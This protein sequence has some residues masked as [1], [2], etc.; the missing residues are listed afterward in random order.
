VTLRLEGLP[1]VQP[2]VTLPVTATGIRGKPLLPEPLGRFYDERCY[3]PQSV[4]GRLLELYQASDARKSDSPLTEFVKDLLGLDQ[5]DALIDGLRDAGDIRRLRI[6]LP[7]YAE[8]R[9]E[10]QDQE[11]AIRAHNAQLKELSSQIAFAEDTL[12]QT[13]SA[14]LLNLNHDSSNIDLL[15]QQLNRSAEERR[16]SELARIQRRLEAARDEWQSIAISTAAEQ[17]QRLEIQ[18]AATREHA[19]RW[20]ASSGRELEA[21]VDELANLFPDL[22]SPAATDP[23][24]AR[25]TGLRAV[26]KEYERVVALF[27]Q[28][29]ADTHRLG[30][31]DQDLARAQSRATILDQQIASLATN[32]GELARA[33]ASIAPHIHTEDCPVCGRNFKEVSER[34]LAAHVSARIATLTE[35]AGRLQAL[36][37]EKA[38]TAAAITQSYSANL[39][40][41]R[42]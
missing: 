6:P 16:L 5:L 25:T 38:S 42:A 18:A 14:L 20:K 10:I 34:P 13:L 37:Q 39:R 17:R 9:A 26:V 1:G 27:A 15:R 19:E 3:L 29:E 41:W 7:Q 30:E 4:L 28:D 8:V 11:R 23:E 32:A 12:K 2:E 33:L 40:L 35:N 22:P 24:F 36:S 21:V 31:L